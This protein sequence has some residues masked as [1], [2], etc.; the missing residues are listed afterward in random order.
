MDNYTNLSIKSLFLLK[1]AAAPSF[2]F[3]FVL[4]T[5]DDV[6]VNLQVKMMEVI[7]LDFF[8]KNNLFSNRPFPMRWA[9]TCLP[10]PPLCSSWAT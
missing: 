3:P 7:F 9:S 5:D 2:P 10:S 4:K 6:Y 8:Y 1:L